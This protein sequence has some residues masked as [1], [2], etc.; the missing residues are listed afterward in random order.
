M[1]LATSTTTASAT[2]HL[3]L[4]L[5]SEPEGVAAGGILSDLEVDQKG[6]RTDVMSMLGEE[7]RTGI[8]L[9]GLKEDTEGH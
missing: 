2:G 1:R 7:D 3:L 6:L 8:I 9:G 5:A 4:A